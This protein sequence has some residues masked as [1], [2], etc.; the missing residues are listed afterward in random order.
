MSNRMLLVL[1]AMCLAAL[2]TA[3]RARALVNLQAVLSAN[4]L[5]K[6]SLSAIYIDAHDLT[7]PHTTW[8]R[9][10]TPEASL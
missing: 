10:W 9:L 3:R 8:R 5:P 4:W 7:R 1:F 6:L 2:Y